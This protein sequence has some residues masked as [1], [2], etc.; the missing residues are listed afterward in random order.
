MKPG[1]KRSVCAPDSTLEHF[2]VVKK[3]ALNGNFGDFQILV[4]N[5]LFAY[6]RI[7]RAKKCSKVDFDLLKRYFEV[8]LG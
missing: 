3:R 6:N 2:K 5:G 8:V 1:S 4:K 7:F